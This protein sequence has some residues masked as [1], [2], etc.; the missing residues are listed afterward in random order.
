[1]EGGLSKT[2]ARFRPTFPFRKWVNSRPVF[3]SV[4]FLWVGATVVVVVVAA[5]VAVA[6]ADV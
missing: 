2:P 5:D 1:M 6:V 4:V 3:L